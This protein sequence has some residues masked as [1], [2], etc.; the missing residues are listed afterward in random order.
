MITEKNKDTAQKPENMD[1]VLEI[2]GGFGKFQYLILVLIL[3]MEI[4]CAFLMFV[5][6]FIGVSPSE[7][8]CDNDT[9]SRAEACSCQGTLSAVDPEAI[10]VTEWNLICGSSWVPDAVVSFQMSGMILGNFYISQVSDWYVYILLAL[11]EVQ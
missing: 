2:L 11:Q 5:P 4:P 3:S 7:W 6:I 8:L 9:V 1:Q 10:V